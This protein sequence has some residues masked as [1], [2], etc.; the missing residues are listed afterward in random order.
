MKCVSEVMQVEMGK[1]SILSGD[2]D[3]TMFDTVRTLVVERTFWKRDVESCVESEGEGAC[4]SC[5]QWESC[6]EP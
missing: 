5:F 1:V 3:N 2:T 4:R 6:W